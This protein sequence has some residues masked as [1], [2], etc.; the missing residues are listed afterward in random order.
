MAVKIQDYYETL[1][2]PRGASA[3]EIKQAFRKLARL[4]HPDMARNKATG[5]AKFNEINEADE[6]LGDLYAVVRLR[7][8]PVV[9][10]GEHALGVR[11][12]A[13]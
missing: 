3:E 6:V 8:P 12:A 9:T 13:A 4:Y 1:A 2:V 11:L 10:I 5:E 7:V